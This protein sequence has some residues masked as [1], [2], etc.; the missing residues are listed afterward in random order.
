MNWA[1]SKDRAD[2]AALGFAIES[3]NPVIDECF[4]SVKD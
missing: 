2:L 1:E 3:L 4:K